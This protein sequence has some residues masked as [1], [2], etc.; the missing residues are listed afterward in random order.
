MSELNR[1]QLERE[2]AVYDQLNKL[3]K[4]YRRLRRRDELDN[5]P[6]GA[7]D[8]LDPFAAAQAAVLSRRRAAR[9]FQQRTANGE[10]GEP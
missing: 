10:E 7:S 3:D 2:A 6:S 8:S 5:S 4:H 9:L 1:V